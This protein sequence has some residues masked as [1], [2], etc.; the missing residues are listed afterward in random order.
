MRLPLVQSVMVVEL[1]VGC[2][3]QSSIKSTEV[4]DERTGVTV[5][6]L[7]EPIEFV[8]TVQNAVQGN[9][10]RTSFAYLGPVEWD[11]SGEITYGLWVHI[12]PGNDRQVGDIRLRGA[13]TLILDDGP[14]VLSP[15]DAPNVGSGPYRPIVSWGQT[16]YFGLDVAMLKRAAGSEKLVLSFRGVDQSIVDFTPTH[17]TR[18]TLEKFTHARGITDD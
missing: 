11:K 12:A 8:E 10:R 15:M 18:T 3:G 1:L 5:G 16:G 9:D 2:A 14:A 4:V 6:A 7:Q 13:V 17:E